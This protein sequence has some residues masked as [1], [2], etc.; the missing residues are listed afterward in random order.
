MA[1][2]L[3]ENLALLSRVHTTAGVTGK[4][5]GETIVSFHL[6]ARNIMTLSLHCVRLLHRTC[7]WGSSDSTSTYH[8]SFSQ[9][10]QFLAL[11]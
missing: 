6:E 3:P 7:G 1:D 10:Y 5:A 4:A 9:R 8:V 11:F 2:E